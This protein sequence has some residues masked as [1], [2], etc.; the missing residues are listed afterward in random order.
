MTWVD[1]HNRVDGGSI[2]CVCVS[3][4]QKGV[5]DNSL[6]SIIFTS[7]EGWATSYLP[8][9]AEQAGKFLIHVAIPVPAADCIID[10]TDTATGTGI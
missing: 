10:A 7:I 1:I 8:L 9:A 4:F 6:A 3:M 2:G 5:L